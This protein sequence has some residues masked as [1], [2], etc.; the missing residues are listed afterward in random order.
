MPEQWVSLSLRTLSSLRNPIAA[1]LKSK[2]ES[3][4]ATKE[5]ALKGGWGY[6]GVQLGQLICGANGFAEGGV[7]VLLNMF[8]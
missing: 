4:A 8:K 2:S 6:G 3:K 5:A 7:C 1:D